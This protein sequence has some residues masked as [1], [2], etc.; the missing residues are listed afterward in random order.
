[1][2]QKDTLTPR[3]LSA[4]LFLGVL[5][6]AIRLLPKAPVAFAGTAAW[7][8]P[9]AAAAPTALF[10][11][12]LMGFLRG[13][14]EG[15]GLGEL[16]LRSLGPAAGR[17]VCAGVAL[18]L[19]FYSGFTLRVSAERLLSSIY[20][21]G[22]VLLFAG[23][24][25]ATAA[26]LAAGTLRGLARTAEVFFPLAVTVLTV[27]LA[28]AVP[29][30]KAEYLLPVSR[31]DLP[32]VLRAALP[33]TN[34]AGLYGYAGFLTGYL[35][36]GRR[37]RSRAVFRR[38]AWGFALF[39]AILFMT[40]GTLSAEMIGHIHNPVFTMIQNVHFYGDTAHI[41]A[42]IVVLWVAM[43][44]FWLGTLFRIQAELAGLI[45]GLR[46][47]NRLV[48]PTAAAAMAVCLL[49]GPTQFDLTRISDRVIPGVQLALMFVVLPGVYL[50][51]KLRK[52][53]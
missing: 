30:L 45:A 6:A 21:S 10:T 25:A 28:A 8:A 4:L 23:V 48:W 5:S 13:R 53:L 33:V 32:G 3:Q 34:L 39:T 1:M 40:V 43:D 42:L 49:T 16:A 47:R 12:I 2:K 38:L 36:P 11:L 20:K 26:V 51:G 35:P 31:L 27:V 7:L 29:N 37:E 52:R 41:D 44:V 9:A 14:R 24:T 46:R 15:E 22:G 50:V 19:L 18:W 17:A